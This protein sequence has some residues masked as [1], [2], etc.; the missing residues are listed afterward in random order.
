MSIF[1]C[2]KWSGAVSNKWGTPNK[3]PLGNQ[4]YIMKPDRLFQSGDDYLLPLKVSGPT[5]RLVRQ[6]T[7]NTDNWYCEFIYVREKDIIALKGAIN[8]D[9]LSRWK[10]RNHDYVR[11][12]N[13]FIHYRKSFSGIPVW[14]QIMVPYPVDLSGP[15]ILDHR[16]I[17]DTEGWMQTVREV[18]DP[19]TAAVL[20]NWGEIESHD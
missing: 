5:G 16:Y 18:T 1:G 9:Q 8:I 12:T 4:Q 6:R 15:N 13:G 10:L 20:E 7:G 17:R 19:V 11:F 3:S 14:Y 2:R